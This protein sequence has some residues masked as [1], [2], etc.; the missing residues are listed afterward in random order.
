MIL[1]AVRAYFRRGGSTLRKG[2]LQCF[3]FL[4]LMMIALAA[5]G[6]TIQVVPD[7]N[8]VNQGESFTLTFSA[9]E[10]PDGDPDFSPLRNDFDILSQSSGSQFSMENGKFSRSTEWSLVLMPKR[11][12]NLTLPAISFGKDQSPPL[13]ILVQAAAAQTP[14]GDADASLLLEMEAVPNNPYVQAQVILSVRVLRRIGMTDANLADPVVADALVQ[15]LAEDRQY[16]IERNGKTY[17]VVERRFALFPQKSGTLHIAP[18]TLEA[19]IVD[20]SRSRFNSF[21]QPSRVTRVQSKPIDLDV[22]PVP[23]EFAGKHWLPAENLSLEQ[24]WSRTPP[25]TTT[26]EPITRTLNL[27]ALGATVGVLP[28][29][30]AANAPPEIKA[31]PDQPALHEEKR[32]EGVS[33]SRQEKVALIPTRSGRQVLPAIEIPWWNTMEDRLEIARLPEQVIVVQAAAGG[34]P[35]QAPT[36]AELAPSVMPA[37]IAPSP[38]TES[39]TVYRDPWFWTSGLLGIAWLGTGLAWWRTSSSRQTKKTSSPG[40]R[41]E[42][43]PDALR[44]DLLAACRADDPSRA[45]AALTN[46]IKTLWPE[47][48]P[49][50][51]LKKRLGSAMV[52]ELEMLERALYAQGASPWRGDNLARLVNEW[53]KNLEPSHR[54]APCALEP[55]YKG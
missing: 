1:T 28:E 8:P 49:A 9:E 54:P 3:G 2:S 12:G 15:R 55:L 32:A 43:A 39:V 38:T 51:E 5:L 41:A 22:R 30:D 50:S 26:A 16:N 37:P 11:A 13:A 6:G 24:S 42:N 34:E 36:T 47:P 20:R 10:S 45:R 25:N 31:Y 44:K 53:G 19:Q 27:R 21:F 40:L 35:T 23:A 7:R 52:Q 33:S 18:L 46:W 29:L 17:A 4:G 14:G 48:L